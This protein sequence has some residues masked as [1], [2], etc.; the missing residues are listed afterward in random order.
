MKSDT[1]RNIGAQNQILNKKQ[2]GPGMTMKKLDKKQVSKEIP[3]K[4]VKPKS[5]SKR[6]ARTSTKY[7]K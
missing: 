7:R 4:G 1:M 3:Q 6:S 5:A 2:R